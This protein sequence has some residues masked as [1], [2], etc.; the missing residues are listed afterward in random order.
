M[1]TKKDIIYIAEYA[2]AH[3]WTCSQKKCKEVLIKPNSACIIY[4]REDNPNF[5]GTMRE[6]LREIAMGQNIIKVEKL[7]RREY[8]HKIKTD[9]KNYANKDAAIIFLSMPDIF[10]EIQKDYGFS[11]QYDL[12]SYRDYKKTEQ[13]GHV[14]KTGV[15]AA[16]T[17]D[18]TMQAMV[19]SAKK[20][21]KPT[22]QPSRQRHI[23]RPAKDTPVK[24]TLQSLEKE[25][26]GK[27]I[28]TGSVK[29]EYSELDL[30]KA[31]VINIIFDR[32]K[33]SYDKMIEGLVSANLSHIQYINLFITLVKSN[34]AEDFLESWKAHEPGIK[35]IHV[36]DDDYLFL[37][38]ETNYF[39]EVSTL[40]YF[41]DEWS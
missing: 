41:K 8:I 15:N 35:E 3:I 11:C 32:L 37:Q 9:I 16:T 20:Q 23:E 7:S 17:A 29:R 4:K 25:I 1:K 10:E 39:I 36:T 14:I 5:Q 21:K 26:F 34:D 33:T 6:F 24:E 28:T 13:K 22:K 12:Q 27:R 40:L 38:D 19:S 18:N 31:N 2:S 30:A